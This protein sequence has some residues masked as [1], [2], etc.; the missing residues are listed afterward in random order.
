MSLLKIVNDKDA[1]TIEQYREVVYD[2]INK[3]VHT[4]MENT[5]KGI[6]GSNKSIEKIIR[7]EYGLLMDDLFPLVFNKI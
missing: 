1:Y 7:A 2:T 4:R 5:L 3:S 6:G